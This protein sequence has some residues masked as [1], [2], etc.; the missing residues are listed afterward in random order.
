MKGW[1]P[2]GGAGLV[3]PG[4]VQ[5]RSAQYTHAR[6]SSKRRSK[7]VLTLAIFPKDVEPLNKIKY[8][9]FLLMDQRLLGKPPT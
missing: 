5:A 3:G 9:L 2:G 6:T 7:D 8:L 1:G 4:G